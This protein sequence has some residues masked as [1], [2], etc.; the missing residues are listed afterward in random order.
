MVNIPNDHPTFLLIDFPSYSSKNFTPW[1]CQVMRK[2]WVYFFLHS[3]CN[4]QYPF[5][6][7]SYIAY[8]R[9]TLSIM[10]ILLLLFGASKAAFWELLLIRAT[11]SFHKAYFWFGQVFLNLMY[12]F[13]KFL[14]QYWFASWSDFRTLV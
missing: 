6:N 12:W 9:I 14:L 13:F 8:L 3:L 11:I 10:K 5:F 2:H 4:I 1:S 7:V